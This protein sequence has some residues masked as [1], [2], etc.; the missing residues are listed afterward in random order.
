MQKTLKMGLFPALFWGL[1]VRVDRKLMSTW[2]YWLAGPSQRTGQHLIPGPS[3]QPFSQSLRGLGA[4]VCSVSSGT[5]QKLEDVHTLSPACPMLPLSPATLWER[6]LIVPSRGQSSQHQRPTP[7][8]VLPGP[9]QSPTFLHLSP[10]RCPR[11][12]ILSR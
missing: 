2:N 10:L 7:P 9:G 8:H 11:F 3:S 12:Y 6:D 5:L 4:E 1:R